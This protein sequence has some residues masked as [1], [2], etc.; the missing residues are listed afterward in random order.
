MGNSASTSAAN[1]LQSIFVIDPL[2]T[3]PFLV[4]LILSMKKNKLDTKRQFWN[5]TG[6]IVSTSYLFL[7]LFVQSIVM[8]K[9]EKQLEENPDYSIFVQAMKETGFFTVLNTVNPDLSKR[10]ITAAV[11]TAIVGGVLGVVLSADLEQP[12]PTQA[13]SNNSQDGKSPAPNVSINVNVTREL[14]MLVL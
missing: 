6:L 12:K 5:R 7:T 10:W 3:L 4:F 1:S 11:A 13:A 9:F 2:Y 14:Q 8:N